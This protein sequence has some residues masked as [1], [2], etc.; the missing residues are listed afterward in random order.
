MLKEF[1]N[2][3][4]KNNLIEKGDKILLALS[5]GIDSMVLA[6]LLILYSQRTSS[7]VN[8]QSQCHLSF[9]H[10]NFHLRG[11]DSNRDEKFVTEFAEENKIPKNIML[12]VKCPKSIVPQDKEKYPVGSA[13]ITGLA[14][15]YRYLCRLTGLSR[16]LA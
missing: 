9:A 14:L 7:T 12:R 5:G 15:A 4:E 11:D 1:K 8:S 13:Y 6:K 16:L 2:F 10:C 3:V